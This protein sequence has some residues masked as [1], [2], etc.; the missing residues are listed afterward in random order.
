MTA[1]TV[2]A[3]VGIGLVVVAIALGVYAIGSPAEER[4]RRVDERRIRALQGL[5]GIIDEYWRVQGRLPPSVA[6]LMKDPR[7]VADT[8]DPVTG[9]EFPYRR[10]T[11][12]TYQVCA[13]FA[14]PGSGVSDRGSWA[15]PSGRH[16]FD[17]EVHERPR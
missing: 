17:L 1:R 15:H 3:G 4:A 9:Q 7:I 2:V 5:T 16:C 6:E 13:E 10:V 14:R 11:D 8:K 12:R